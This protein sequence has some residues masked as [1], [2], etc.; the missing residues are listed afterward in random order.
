M[1]P[2]GPLAAFA[3]RTVR[4]GWSISRRGRRVIIIGKSV[5]HWLLLATKKAISWLLLATKKAMFYLL[6]IKLWYEDITRTKW[7]VL[8]EQI[9]DCSDLVAFIMAL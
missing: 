5:V 9:R 3:H 7:M 8:G 2:R 6:T 1:L 4:C